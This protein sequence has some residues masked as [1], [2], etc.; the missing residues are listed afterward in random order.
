[1]TPSS[2]AVSIQGLGKRYRLGAT[3]DHTTLRDRLWHDLRR[4][5]R[6]LGAAVPGRTASA[7][8]RPRPELWALRDIA[9]DIAPGEVIGLIGRNGAGKS[10]LLKILSEITEPT[11]GRV[12]LRGRVAS[13]LEVGTGFHFELTGRENVYLNGAILGMTR[14]EIRARFDAI[15]DFAGV[16]AFI[17]TPVKRYSTGM[18]VRLAFAVAAHLEAE[19]L[20]IDEVL[21]VGDLEFQRRC[22]GKMDDV[23]HSGRT[24]IFV[25][26]N[27]A[28][29]DGLC[30]RSVLLD[31]GRV[32]ADGPSDDVIRRYVALRDLPAGEDRPG[33]F[34]LHHRQAPGLPAP[35]ITALRLLGP[36]G[37][38]V[39]QVP[40]GGR[41]RLVLDLHGMRAHRTACVG[42]AVRS[43][44]NQTLCSFTGNMA[45]EWQ[46]ATR[47]EDEEA[48]FEIEAMPLTPGRYVLD[49]HILLPGP[50]FLDRVEHAAEFDVVDANVYGNGTQVTSHHGVFFLRGCWQIRNR[51]ATGGT[52]P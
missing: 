43:L 44:Y 50:R 16:S 18:A 27:M 15:V 17:D 21:A 14:R 10:T 25:S 42:F 8:T 19:I 23:A 2:H 28:A 7:T 34:P 30:P 1:M 49:V 46:A 32:I 20:L 41:L 51:A 11:E 12:T 31:G 40:M 6:R 45:C 39:S 5:R 26:H 48:T 24:V 33:V 13:L 29:V 35:L 4:A 22:L 52:P 9:F 36:N 38:G 37:D 47:A 3:V